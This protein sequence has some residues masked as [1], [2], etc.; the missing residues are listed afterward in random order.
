MSENV[1]L[2]REE[3]A[4]SRVPRALN[5]S[6]QVLDLAKE[7]N[8]LGV[9][10]G[11]FVAVAVAAQYGD[12]FNSFIVVAGSAGGPHSEMPT[13]AVQNEL[14][15]PAITALQLRNL[16]FPLDKPQGWRQLLAFF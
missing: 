3:D 10:M 16:S 15:N 6:S 14:L 8:L 2:S 5:R 7:P 4:S 1:I 12:A 13:P 9:S 11:G